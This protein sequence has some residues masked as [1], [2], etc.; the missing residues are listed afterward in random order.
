MNKLRYFAAGLAAVVMSLSSFGVANFAHAVDDDT[1]TLVSV[2]AENTGGTS[3]IEEGDSLVFT[4]SEAVADF[5]FTEDNINDILDLNNSHSFLDGDGNLGD[6]D[7]SDDM[8]ELTLELSDGTS[9]PTVAVGDTV[10][11]DGDDL[12]DEDDNVFTGSA[13]ISGSFTVDDDD[14]EDEDCDDVSASVDDDDDEDADENENEDC[15]DDSDNPNKICNNALQNGKLYKIGSEP[16][17]YL[18][19]RHCVLKPFRGQAAFHARGHKFTDVIMLSAKPDGVTISTEPALPAEGT[20]VKGTDKTVWFISHE[21]KRRGF[22]NADVFTKL[23]FKFTQV[24]TITDSDLGTMPVDTS[25]I[26]DDTEH[27]DGAIVKCGNSPEVFRVKDGTRFPFPSIEVFQ[28]RGHSFE[29]IAVVD[30]GRYGYKA[31]PVLDED[32]E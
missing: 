8:T 28:N 3:A 6:V 21:G 23:G 9:L 10:T 30:C 20:L 7:W 26:S 19:V 22:V 4:F 25:N 31:G 24:E 1:P 17:V 15:D 27:P 5:E 12:M 32:A 2:V 11:I 16:T 18:A 14:D 29:H 13:V